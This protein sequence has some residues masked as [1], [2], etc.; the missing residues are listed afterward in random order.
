MSV[1]PLLWFTLV[2]PSCHYRSQIHIII[3]L[4]LK[5]IHSFKRYI[6]F[7]DHSN[8]ETL[9]K[10]AKLTSVPSPLIHRTVFVG[11]THIFSIF[12]HCAL[13]DK[14]TNEPLDSSL[15]IKMEK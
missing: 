1:I 2:S 7:L 15:I 13:S 5:A 9:L 12:L 8:A 14:K 10:T 4:S 3:Y 11:E 6:T